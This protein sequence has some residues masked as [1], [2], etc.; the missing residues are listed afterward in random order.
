MTTKETIP[1]TKETIPKFISKDAYE[2]LGDKKY[3]Y[4]DTKPYYLY[5][6][7]KLHREAKKV[8]LEEQKT[9][10]KKIEEDKQKRR[11]EINQP[12]YDGPITDIEYSELITD[13]NKPL[14][15]GQDYNQHDGFTSYRKI[16]QEE[17]PEYKLELLKSRI[18]NTTD[19]EVELSKDEFES[20]VPETERNMW[21]EV[22]TGAPWDT[23]YIYKRKT[24]EDIKQEK[25]IKIQREKNK[26]LWEFMT[27][28]AKKHTGVGYV[29]KMPDYSVQ[30]EK[31]EYYTFN[32]ES[33]YNEYIRIENE[34]LAKIAAIRGGKSKKKRSYIKNKT[35]RRY[36]VK[37]NKA[38]KR[39]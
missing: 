36:G 3:R 31:A 19:F 34:Y 38:H 18:A 20:Y 4:D 23:Y 25:V 9:Q 1:K 30:T 22:S 35:L 10:Q 21:K 17:T 2:L 6:Y 7:D 16:R 5:I 11:E 12:S 26:K 28:N 29:S 15:T 8:Q 27:K 33:L 24:Q 13:E 14:W 39:K 32:S 37:S